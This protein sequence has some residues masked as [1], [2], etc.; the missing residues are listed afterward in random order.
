MS[1]TQHKWT[2][3]DNCHICKITSFCINVG[4]NGVANKGTCLQIGDIVFVANL[5]GIELEE[6]I[7]HDS[8]YP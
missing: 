2:V 4:Q 8:T 6:I 5:F 7:I 1:I 3:W